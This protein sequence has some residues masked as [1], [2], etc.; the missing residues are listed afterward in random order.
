MER[1]VHE[2][3]QIPDVKTL[4]DRLAIYDVLVRHT[5]GVAASAKGQ[6][7]PFEGLSRGARD[8]TDSLYVHLDG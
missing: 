8:A 7:A 1:A 3:G 2:T 4:A 5:H 6:G